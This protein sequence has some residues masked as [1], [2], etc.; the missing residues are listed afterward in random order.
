MKYLSLLQS[1]GLSGIRVH[2][3]GSLIKK[4]EVG[5]A[6]MGKEKIAVTPSIGNEK[7]I[8]IAN[9]YNYKN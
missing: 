7:S 8:F 2:M 5:K 1:T 3:V 4:C 6:V 9:K